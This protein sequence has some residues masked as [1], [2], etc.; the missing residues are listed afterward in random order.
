[1]VSIASAIRQANLV[2]VL[3]Y[4]V[5]GSG[6]ALALLHE[7]IVDSRLWGKMVPLFAERHTVVNYDQRGY[8]RSSRP[9]GP[10]SLAE[11]LAWVLDAAGAERAAIVGASRGGRIALD[12]ALTRPERVDALILVV[13]GLPGHRF[14]V[15]MSPELEARWE[16]AEATGDYAAMAE[17]DLEIWA[18]LGV[19]SELRAM[20]VENAEWS[21]ADDP[22]LEAAPPAAERLGEITAPTL[23]VTADRDIP[24]MTEIGDILFQGIP[25]ARRAVITAADHVVPWRKPEELTWLIVEFLDD[26]RAVRST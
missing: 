2:R 16:Q 17:I 8:G 10:Y 14:E 24:Q 26:A 22:G 19:D 3:H 5:T 13:S 12:F 18:P 25:G 23:V 9:D 6:P 15:D 20:A 7:G 21:N 4:E 1:M 11:D